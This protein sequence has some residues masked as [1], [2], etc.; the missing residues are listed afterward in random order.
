MNATRKVKWLVGTGIVVATWLGGCTTSTQGSN[1]AAPPTTAVLL[2]AGPS[3]PPPPP[4]PPLRVNQLGYV[5]GWRKYAMMVLVS[6]QPAKWELVDGE[7][8]V[9]A[10]GATQPTGEDADSGDTLHLIDFSSFQGTGTGFR[11][12]VGVEE[13]SPFDVRADLFRQ[14]KQDAIWYFYHNRSGIPIELPYAGQEQWT[15]PAGHL[16][17]RAVPCAPDAKC[18]YSLDVS[19]GWYDAGDH[20]KYVVNGGISAWTL[21]DLYERLV[22]RSP[23]NLAD[24]ADGKLRLPEQG[25]GVPDLLDE[26]RW[27]VEWLMKMQVPEGQPNAGMAHHKMHDDSWTSLGAPPPTDVAEFKVKRVLRPVST[28]ATLNLAATAAQA[29]RIWKDIDPTF[30]Q[31]CLTSAERAW[32]AALAHPK[33]LAPESDHTGGGPYA[34][35][36]VDD[37]FYWAA[38][39]LFITTAKDEYRKALLAS[40]FHQ[41]VPDGSGYDGKGPQ[42]LL[43]WQSV[44]AAGTVSLAIVPNEL[45]A[46][47]IE[48]ARAEIVRL[49]DTY[50]ATRDHEG[51]RVPFAAD[52]GEYPWG[53]NSFVVNNALALALAHDFT[54]DQK[55]LVGATD[56]LNYLLGANGMG[57]SYVSGYGTR[58]LQNPH[59]RFWAHQLSPDFPPPIPGCLS[60]GPNSSLQDPTTREAGLPGC[61]PQKCYIDNVNAWSVN[62]ITINWNAPLVWVA[63]YLDEQAEPA[64]AATAEPEAPAATSAAGASPAASMPAPSP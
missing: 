5:P 56:A 17:D 19:G 38:V 62:E 2:G 33:V 43:T 64:P 39:E 29:A 50:L 28:A 55:Y 9:V 35:E 20:G 24:F 23:A 41:H 61:K 44:S 47:E 51:Y 11:L 15:R 14:L 46:G 32:R 8:E 48:K 10:A 54:R 16:S 52:Q 25:N 53:S 49:A 13:S 31:Q 12:R 59:H 27:E 36:R 63:A 37:E 60:G 1:V 21:L 6:P 30:S 57:Q 58:A 42:T 45:G 40:K 34:D 4:A 18:D 7:G 26:A 22:H 3:I